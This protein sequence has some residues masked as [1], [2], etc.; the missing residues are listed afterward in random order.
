[1]NKHKLNYSEI[2]TFI[3]NLEK[4]IS[5]KIFIQILHP[6]KKIQKYKKEL[7]ENMLHPE[8]KGNGLDC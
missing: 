4:E 7:F 6:N 5:E 3:N 1:M 2:I 8:K